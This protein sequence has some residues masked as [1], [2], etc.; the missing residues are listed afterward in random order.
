LPLQ[1]RRGPEAGRAPR[2]AEADPVGRSRQA[3]TKILDTLVEILGDAASDAGSTPAA[4]TKPNPDLNTIYAHQ[5]A[6]LPPKVHQ[7]GGR[8]G[9]QRGL[10][11]ALG[12]PNPPG[13]SELDL[14]R[15]AVFVVLIALGA[16]MLTRAFYAFRV[17]RR[18]RKRL[19]LVRLRRLMLRIEPALPM[20]K[21]EPVL[22]ML[23]I[24][25]ALNRLPKLK[26][27]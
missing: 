10:V 24:D 6:R 12:A 13:R 15:R 9:G 4:S 22:P 14:T 27:L 7:L 18:P 25:P 5:S 17:A 2:L 21:I 3:R 8:F 16:F 26:T 11:P 23:K 19:D 1:G 20:L